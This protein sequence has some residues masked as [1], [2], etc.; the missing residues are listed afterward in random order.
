[1]CLRI[2]VHDV[3]P[4]FLLLLRK[5]TKKENTNETLKKVARLV[6]SVQGVDSGCIRAYCRQHASRCPTYKRCSDDSHLCRALQSL[7]PAS[8][9]PVSLSHARSLYVMS[10]PSPM[11]G[12]TANQPTAISTPHCGHAPPALQVPSGSKLQP[13]DN[14][15]PGRHF[16]NAGLE[17]PSPCHLQSCHPLGTS[18]T[19]LPSLCRPAPLQP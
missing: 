17:A 3:I 1:V 2:P 7:K 6:T 19:F 4:R 13:I 14:P 5:K 8:F 18:Y 9:T 11:H 16:S 10:P 12:S 15:I